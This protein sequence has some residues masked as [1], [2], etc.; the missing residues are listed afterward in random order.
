MRNTEIVGKTAA[1]FIDFLVKETGI[2]TENIHFLGHSLGAHVAGNAGSSMTSGRLGRITGLDPALPG[3]H[4][5]T[6]DKTRLDSTDAFFVDVIHSCGGV[7]GF[8]QPLGSADFYPNAGTAVQPGCCCIPEVIE[9]CSHGRAYVYFTESISSKTGFMARKCNTW[10]Q[11]MNDNCSHSD[12]ALMGEHV[13][14][15][16]AGTYFLRTRSESP[17]VYQEE[18]ISNTI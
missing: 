17:Y 15:A 8:L 5:L 6:S 4:L 9:A 13:D 2:K 3:F 10:D 16:A 14:K 18:I 12:T 1:D 7:L 11:F